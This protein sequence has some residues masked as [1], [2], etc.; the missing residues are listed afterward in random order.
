MRPYIIIYRVPGKIF[1]FYEARAFDEQ[2]Y[3]YRWVSPVYFWLWSARYQAPGHARKYVNGTVR[4]LT[5]LCGPG[6]A[7]EQVTL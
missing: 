5:D 4:E 1:S 3:Q 7:V 2:G 6:V